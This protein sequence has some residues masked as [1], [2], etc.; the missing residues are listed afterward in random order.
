MHTKNSTLQVNK[1]YVVDFLFKIKK[2][3][4][5]KNLMVLLVVL[6]LKSKYEVS[7]GV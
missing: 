3:R 4:I 5:S 2:L 7:R 1:V 6:K